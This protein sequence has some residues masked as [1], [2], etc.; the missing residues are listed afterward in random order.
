MRII[1]IN[2]FLQEEESVD[3]LVA[4]LLPS[5]GWTLFY[6]QRG[7]GKTTFAMQ[8][9]EALHTGALF[10]GRR[11]KQTNIVY[12]QADSVALEWKAIL[13]RVAPKSIAWT[14]VSVPAYAMDNPEYRAMLSTMIHR[15]GMDTGFI[16][17]DSLYN[18]TQKDINSKNILT[19]ITDMNIM[20][21]N[22]P[23]MLIHHPRKDGEIYSG[24]NSIGGNC[25]NEWHLL[26]NKI[27]IEK[28][29]LVKAKEVLLSRDSQGLWITKDADMS[30]DIDDMY[31]PL[32]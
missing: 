26:R 18:L 31:R 17:F 14:V 2:K 15:T 11:T 7:L 24:H 32:F 25:S 21:N 28:G 30:I 3:W 5:V 8:M 9:C 6:G 23:W 22:L 4:D 1:R 27:K 12:I 13:G 16:V 29:R 10:L 20:A 19:T